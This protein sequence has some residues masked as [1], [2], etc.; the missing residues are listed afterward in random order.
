MSRITVTIDRV[1]LQGFD[2]AEQ[3]ALVSAL[4]SEL[5]RA[6]TDPASSAALAHS[7][8]VPVLKLGTITREPGA[9]GAR[10]LGGHIA[11]AIGKGGRP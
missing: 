5:A 7:R 10:R 9:P 8:Q 4:R 1:T 11:R 3:R 6:L 2:P